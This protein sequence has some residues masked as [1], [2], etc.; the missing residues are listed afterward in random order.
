MLENIT[1]GLDNIISSSIKE[2][3]STKQKSDLK[4]NS[5]STS[6]KD[7][8]D[9]SEIAKKINSF[10]IDY[11]NAIFSKQSSGFN[12]NFNF[13][14]SSDLKI[15]T[16]GIFSSKRKSIE[17]N[18]NFVFER[19]VMINGSMQKKKFEA[20]IN[21]TSV[22]EENLSVSPY[23]KKEDIVKFIQRVV[24]EVLEVAFEDDLALKGVVLDKKDLEEIEELEDGK[25]AKLLVTVVNLA[26]MVG[27]IKK[28]IKEDEKIEDVILAPKRKE[29][30]GLEVNKSKI[31]I[32]NF[33]VSINEISETKQ[34]EEEVEEEIDKSNQKN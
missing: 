15:N 3:K 20:N 32:E 4:D 33:S 23:N 34:I 10:D 18:L 21:F 25:I 17:L 28:Q 6:I 14:E 16:S 13:N 26:I 2:P 7:K 31:K 30:E 29:E 8:V 11:K 27:K 22:L 19:E 5:Q 1:A 12:F 9:L 24:D